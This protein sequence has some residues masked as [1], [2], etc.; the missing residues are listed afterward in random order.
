MDNKSGF[1]RVKSLFSGTIYTKFLTILGLV[2]ILQIPIS[3]IQGV[4]SDR[5]QTR[6]DAEVFISQRSGSDQT[7]VPPILTIPYLHRSANEG[8]E[9]K[10]GRGYVEV[11]PENLKISSS[12]KVEKRY[13]GIF[14]IPI[15]TTTL[16]IEGSIDTNQLRASGIEQNEVITKEMVLNLGIS[17][18]RTIQEVNSFQFDGQSIEAQPGIHNTSFSSSGIHFKISNSGAN[19]VNSVHQFSGV[20]TLGGSQSLRFLPVGRITNVII[21]SD[22]SNPSFVG[23][24]LPLTREISAEGFKASWRI[25]DL[26]RSFPRL[27]NSDRHVVFDPRSKDS[28]FGVGLYSPVDTYR[29]TERAIKY[30]LFVL[31]LTFLAFCM[32]ELFL[33][34]KIHTVQ[35]LLVGA[36]M[37]LFYLL[38]LS[39]SEQLSF[40]PA[41]VL[42][43]IVTIGL[44]GSYSRSVLRHRAGVIIIALSLSMLYGFFFT[45]LQEQELSLLLGSI[46]LTVVL[47][48]VMYLTRNLDWFA[49]GDNG[50]TTL[51]NRYSSTLS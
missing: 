43:S 35:Y 47:G 20:V 40:S 16:T 51:D 4:I 6:A 26:G 1:Q 10:N 17:D 41:Y 12:V 13:R 50:E 36:A 38:L 14:E 48:G 19:F 27:V 28:E 22:W 29:M 49:I 3:C 45:L 7:V 11:L 39:L 5:I 25:L 23:N 31:S 30:E 21:E 15:Y 8:K 34:V 2:V 9:E 18:P 37:V 33:K 42:A 32:F 46:G 44:V 24:Y